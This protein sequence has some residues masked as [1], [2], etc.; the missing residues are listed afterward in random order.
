MKLGKVTKLDKKN[1]TTSKKLMMTSCR[2]IVTLLLFFQFTVNLEQSGSRIPD[3]ESVKLM[4]SLITTFPL[5][6]LTTK[7]KN[8]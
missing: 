5:Q 7:L 8:L 1:K 2:R 4:F 6:K 3:A